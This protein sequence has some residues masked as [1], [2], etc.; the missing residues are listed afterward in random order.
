MPPD[1]EDDKLEALKDQHIREGFLD[2]KEEI[3]GVRARLHDMNNSIN[4]VSLR[5][6]VFE[7]EQR[8]QAKTTGTNLAAIVSIVTVIINLIAVVLMWIHH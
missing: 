5:L 1:H 3:K 6:A 4:A 2:L 8:T 7:T